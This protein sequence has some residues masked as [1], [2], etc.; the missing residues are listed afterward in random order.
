MPYAVRVG[1]DGLL[2][3]GR[4]DPLSA[5]VYHHPSSYGKAIKAFEERFPDHKGQ[6]KAFVWKR[7]V[8]SEI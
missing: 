6:C 2:K 1:N 3:Q 4:V 7:G 5:T 8:L